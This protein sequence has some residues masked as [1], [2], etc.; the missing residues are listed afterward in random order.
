ML[1]GYFIKAPEG[2]KLR[3]LQISFL[4]NASPEY[5]LRND[6]LSEELCFLENQYVMIKEKIYRSESQ[7]EQSE[8]PT[9]VWIHKV[10]SKDDTPI[11]DSKRFKP[12]TNLVN[13]QCG[14]FVKIMDDGD[15]DECQLHIC[16]KCKKRDYQI[17]VQKDDNDL[18]QMREESAQPFE[19]CNQHMI[20]IQNLEI[21]LERQ[22]DRYN[23][24]FFLSKNN[25]RVNFIHPLHSSKQENISSDI[26]NKQ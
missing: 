9:D 5:S 15:P 12:E 24:S 4:K 3:N 7:Q 14:F 17:Q 10:T 19:R 16:L 22:G 25:C 18:P 2:K 13:L 6:Q 11:W 1:E 20:F 26:K 23:Q 8:P 21:E